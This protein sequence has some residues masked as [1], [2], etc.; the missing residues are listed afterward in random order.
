[1]PGGR[2]PAPTNVIWTQRS[3]C[4][5]Q[6][7]LCCLSGAPP[8]ARIAAKMRT[9]CDVFAATPYAPRLMTWVTRRNSKIQSACAM[10]SL[11]FWKRT[12][13]TTVTRTPSLP[14]S[15]RVSAR[16]IH[17]TGGNCPDVDPL[18]LPPAETGTRRSRGGGARR[19]D[20]G[21]IA[22][23]GHWRNRANAKGCAGRHSL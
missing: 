16:S 21:A 8:M 5:Y 15:G 3:C 17:V 9:P 18:G 23:C 13:E 20:W 7:N 14:A 1:V 12:G 11:G 19:P 22:D 10:L 4:P 2:S 6:N